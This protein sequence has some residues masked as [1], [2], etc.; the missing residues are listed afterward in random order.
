MLT[1]K[2][3]QVLSNILVLVQL[4]KNVLKKTVFIKSLVALLSK[5]TKVISEYKD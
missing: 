1:K 5:A 4:I 3:L 2:G